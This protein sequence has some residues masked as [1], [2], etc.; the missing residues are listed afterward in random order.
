VDIPVEKKEI[1]YFL[2]HYIFL[3]HF[4]CDNEHHEGDDDEVDE[5][6]EELFFGTR[7]GE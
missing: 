1:D 7:I 4:L 5:V 6:G 3:Q 2:C